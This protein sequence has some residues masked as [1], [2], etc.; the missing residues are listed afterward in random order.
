MCR[1]SALQLWRVVQDKP[2]CRNVYIHPS[3]SGQSIGTHAVCFLYYCF[4]ITMSLSQVLF[5]VFC[6]AL[7]NFCV[8]FGLWSPFLKSSPES[9]P[10]SPLGPSVMDG[11]VYRASFPLA[12]PPL[13]WIKNGSA[14]IGPA[15]SPTAFMS[16]S[17]QRVLPR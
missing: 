10:V 3:G 13:N 11:S 7:L 5:F 16:E 17:F 1:E 2:L 15:W 12:Q 9:I 4:I 14:W 6:F 8:S